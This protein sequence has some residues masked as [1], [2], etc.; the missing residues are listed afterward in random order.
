MIALI[1]APKNSDTA[2]MV[3]FSLDLMHIFHLTNYSEGAISFRLLLYLSVP[4]IM[5]TLPTSAIFR[6]AVFLINKIASWKK[7]QTKK[8]I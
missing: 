3:T 1:L 4:F 5:G 2:I 8:K 6:E 7:N